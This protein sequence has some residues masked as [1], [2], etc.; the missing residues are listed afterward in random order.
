MDIS[1]I[2][3]SKLLLV[4]EKKGYRF[5]YNFSKFKIKTPVC[6]M[7]FGLETYNNK[8]IINIELSNAT[9]EQINFNATVRM[10]DKL[11]QQFSNKQIQE[12]NVF[13]FINLPAGFAKEVSN[14][15]YSP[16]IKPSL[17]GSII[18]CHVKPNINVIKK[19]NGTNVICS[20]NDLK[21]S[22]AII[23]LELGNIWIHNNKYGLIWYINNIE[24]L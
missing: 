15:E 19:V 8:E 1:N 13:P 12:N 22:N 5:A 6:L 20:K 23:E 18:R 7:P 17:L 24:I 21:K 3:Y 14:M 4:S 2:D 9:N 10:L 11:Y 16:C